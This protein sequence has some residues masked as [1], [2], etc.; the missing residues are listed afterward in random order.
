MSEIDFVVY[1]DP[2]SGE[3]LKWPAIS[4]SMPNLMRGP[5]Y[6]DQGSYYVTM[7]QILPPNRKQEDE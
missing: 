1:L 6:D 4:T 7:I 2:I 3:T 5:Y